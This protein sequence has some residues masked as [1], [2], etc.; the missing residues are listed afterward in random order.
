MVPDDA[1]CQA[2]VYISGSQT[3]GR[4]M[5]QGGQLNIILIDKFYLYASR[6]C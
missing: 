5:E 3:E 4:Q 2:A 1:L 6:D